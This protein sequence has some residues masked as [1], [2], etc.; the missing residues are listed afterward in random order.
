MEKN[1]DKVGEIYEAKTGAMFTYFV[2]DDSALSE[3][4]CLE[5]KDMPYDK[6]T[7]NYYLLDE[8]HNLELIR[9]ETVSSKDVTLFIDIDLFSTYYIEIKEL[10]NH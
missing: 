8:K 10:K 5:I 9:R 6:A 4:L 3:R 7:L 2:D 1:L